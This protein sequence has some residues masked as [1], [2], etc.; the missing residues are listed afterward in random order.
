MRFEFGEVREALEKGEELVLTFRN[1]PLARLLPFAVKK[2]IKDDP[3]LHF[4]D[5]ASSLD[6]MTNTDMD[7]SIYD[8]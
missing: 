2:P 8:L 6:P 4:G 7:H 5:V 3:A 1:R